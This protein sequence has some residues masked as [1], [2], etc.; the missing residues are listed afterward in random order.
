MAEPSTL[1][2]K[3]A[4]YKFQGKGGWTVLFVPPEA[5]TYW[6]PLNGLKIKGKLDAVAIEGIKLMPMGNNIYGFAVK[7][8]LRKQM[9]KEGGDIVLA[10]LCPDREP[11]ILPLDFALALEQFPDAITFFENLTEAEQNY[12]IHWILAAKKE[13]TRHQRIDISIK[14]LKSSKKFTDA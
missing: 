8:S 3:T 6:G 11:L 4:L 10:T 5:N 9:G 12:Y 13:E 2:F 1:T 7:E 14:R